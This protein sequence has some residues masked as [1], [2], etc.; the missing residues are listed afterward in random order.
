MAKKLFV[1]GL[2]YTTT[3]ETL[4]EAFSRAGTVGWGWVITDKMSGG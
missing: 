1:G 2:S 3:E 4:K